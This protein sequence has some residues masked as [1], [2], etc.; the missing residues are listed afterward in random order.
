MMKGKIFEIKRFAVHDG[1]GIRTAVYLKGCSLKCL[2]CHNPEGLCGTPELAFLVHKCVGCG[3]CAQV[4]HCHKIVDGCHVY[5]KANCIACGKCVEVC[6]VE[7]LKLY[8][9]DVTA[10]ELLPTLLED[11]P[12][13]DTSGGG[14][15]VSGGEC[16]M[17]ADFCEELLRTCKEKGLHT[18]VDTC[19]NV[20]WKNVEKVLPYTDV[21]L[22][23]VKAVDKDVHIRCTGVTNQ[24]I[25]E[26]LQKID[27]AGKPIE[28]RIPF[29]P[30]YN[31]DQM[32][33]IGMLLSGLKNLTK[34]R[35]LAYHDMARS[36]YV[37]LQLEDTM[38]PIIPTEEELAKA[39]ETL[40]KHG[41]KC[42]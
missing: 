30:G 5:D 3:A 35:V 6:P 24:R 7:A 2:W 12:F 18:A 42:V 14:I 29:V 9:K 31:S 37:S 17:Q 41:L 36:K 40:E 26:N 25:L 20:P 1:D 32:E 34:V 4:C 39:R 28:V 33:K 21:F 22:Y 23:D 11:K 13:Y 15:T 27:E 19:G 10:E 38:P 16:L 8:G